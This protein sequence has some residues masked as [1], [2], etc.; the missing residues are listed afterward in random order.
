MIGAIASQIINHSCILPCTYACVFT[1]HVVPPTPN[2]CGQFSSLSLFKIYF[3]A[4]FHQLLIDNDLHS[5]SMPVTF[6]IK[7]QIST[8]TQDGGSEPG[9]C[10]APSSLTVMCMLVYMY[11]YVRVPVRTRVCMHVQ[12]K[13]LLYRWLFIVH[14]ERI[15]C[16]YV[17]RFQQCTICVAIGEVMHIHA[18]AVHSDV[19]VAPGGTCIKS[20][21]IH[22]H[23]LYV[24][25]V[26]CTCTQDILSVCAFV[27]YICIVHVH[28]HLCA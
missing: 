9:L 8:C 18:A 13:F 20:H 16:M 21:D 14:V 4:K 6:T 27:Q 7:P 5:G 22:V 17:Y 1:A 19:T 23:V 10:A 3:F 25:T 28:V 26:Y 15:Q 24:Y 2:P 11:M 12:S